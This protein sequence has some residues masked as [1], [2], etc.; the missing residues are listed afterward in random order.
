MV[1]EDK[2]S[3]TLSECKKKG[4]QQDHMILL[5]KKVALRYHIG[6]RT[7]TAPILNKLALK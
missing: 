2:G 5:I 1:V 6:T 3:W 7:R 4:N